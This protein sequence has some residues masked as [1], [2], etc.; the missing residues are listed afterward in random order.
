MAKKLKLLM[1]LLLLNTLSGW[2]QS[3]TN[4]TV[5]EQGKDTIISYN[6]TKPQITKLRVY[7]TSLEETYRLYNIEKQQ[8]K[9]K[10]LMLENYKIQIDNYK[11]ISNESDSII[12]FQKNELIKADNWGKS[13]ERL[14]IKYKN[15]ADKLPYA[16]GG[17]GIIGFIIC[18]LLVK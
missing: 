7:V 18:L 5:L 8:S 3:S 9:I 16:L 13:Q 4:W 14:K 10:D 15:L 2:S 1:M 12:L 11:F 17:G 6:F